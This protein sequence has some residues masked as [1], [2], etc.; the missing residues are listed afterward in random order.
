MPILLMALHWDGRV[1]LGVRSLV[2]GAAGVAAYWQLS[3]FAL[4]WVIFILPMLVYLLTHP[5][6][7]RRRARGGPLALARRLGATDSIQGTRIDDAGR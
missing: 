6:I 5:A 2:S 4:V 3:V 1:V 7:L